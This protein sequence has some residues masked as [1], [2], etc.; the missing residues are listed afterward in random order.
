MPAAGQS[1]T[2][3]PLL[4]PAEKPKPRRWTPAPRVVSLC[5]AYLTE[6]TGDY[7]LLKTLAAACDLPPSTV[8]GHCRNQHLPLSQSRPRKASTKAKLPL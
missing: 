2:P 6:T 7:P 1:N 5:H 3:K 8:Y 4:A